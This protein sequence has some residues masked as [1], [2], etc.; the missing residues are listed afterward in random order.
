MHERATRLRSRINACVEKRRPWAEGEL[1]SIRV[2]IC[3]ERAAPVSRLALRTTPFLA[4]AR[5]VCRLGIVARIGFDVHQCAGQCKRWQSRGFARLD[6]R[7]CARHA[8]IPILQ[9]PTLGPDPF[10]PDLMIFGLSSL[11]GRHGANTTLYEHKSPLAPI[12]SR[13]RRSIDFAGS[14]HFPD[15]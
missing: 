4:A 8:A 11:G 9:E 2:S 1:G 12:N 10:R 13:R 15:C 14:C 3:T 5:L 6:A 7:T